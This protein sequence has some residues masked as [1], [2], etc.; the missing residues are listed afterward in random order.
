VYGD[1]DGCA[2]AHFLGLVLNDEQFQAEGGF[3]TATFE[4]GNRIFMLNEFFQD[5]LQKYRTSLPMYDVTEQVEA[6]VAS[7]PFGKSFPDREIA[8]YIE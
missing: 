8:S 7:N 4:I 2:A 5:L 6:F 3:I 1:I